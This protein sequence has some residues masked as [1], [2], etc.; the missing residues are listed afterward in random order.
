MLDYVEE[1]ALYSISDNATV[2]FENITFTTGGY[3]AREM[4][5]FGIGTGACASDCKFE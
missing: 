1:D 4:I 3:E 5:T 2:R